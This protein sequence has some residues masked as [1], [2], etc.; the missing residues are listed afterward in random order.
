LLWLPKRRQHGDI[1]GIF[2]MSAGVALFITEFWRDP[3]G[4]GAIF[5]GFL[6][7]PQAAA[8]MLVLVGAVLLLERDSQRIAAASSP[9][10]GAQKQS[11]QET[12]H[13]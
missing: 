7:G 2:L 6:K 13:G 8:V 3:I 10:A 4:R 5:G 12:T 11:S 1:T 9:A